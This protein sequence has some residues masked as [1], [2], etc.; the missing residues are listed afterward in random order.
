MYVCILCSPFLYSFVIIILICLHSNRAE[1]YLQASEYKK[2]IHDCNRSLCLDKSLQMKVQRRRARAYQKL[3]L[4]YAAWLDMKCVCGCY[5][6]QCC[7]SGCMQRAL[8]TFLYNGFAAITCPIAT[9][10]PTQLVCCTCPNTI[11][12]APPHM[13]PPP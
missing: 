5:F 3:D 2:A 9:C 13:Y 7:I 4:D 10:P 11:Q 6:V 1:C 12:I 8:I